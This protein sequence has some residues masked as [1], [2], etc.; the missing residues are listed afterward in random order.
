VGCT[1]ID[2]AIGGHSDV[3]KNESSGEQNK[4]GWH[5]GDRRIEKGGASDIPAGLG[6]LRSPIT[7]VARA[8]IASRIPSNPAR[9]Y[10]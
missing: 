2:A 1:G 10:M 5:V 6:K 7:T 8:L 3:G 4:F 9:L